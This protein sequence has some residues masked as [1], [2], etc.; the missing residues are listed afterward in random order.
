MSSQDTKRHRP[1]STDAPQLRCHDAT[2]RLF[3]AVGGAVAAAKAGT[4]AVSCRPV[5]A[6]CSATGDGVWVVTATSAVLRLR[7]GQREGALVVALR[8]ALPASLG[9]VRDCDWDPDRRV[10]LL[11]TSDGAQAFDPDTALS[12]PCGP[13][14]AVDLRCIRCS[15][16]A[17]AVACVADDAVSVFDARTNERAAEVP[18]CEAG[19]VDDIRWVGTTLVA[20]CTTPALCLRAW[21][22]GGADVT[23]LA[24]D[25]EAALGVH[26]DAAAV[27]TPRDWWLQAD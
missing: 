15:V 5:V 23:T 1:E 13:P 25:V 3:V 27:T 9:A 16:A 19:S 11:A 20:L 24:R 18:F 4:I 7:V 12:R 17:G 22:H 21:R 8:T 10:L 14:A 6:M 26:L 2:G